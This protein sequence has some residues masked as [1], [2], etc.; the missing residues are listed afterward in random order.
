M[1]W[2]LLQLFSMFT[3]TDQI[4]WTGESHIHTG[5]HHTVLKL[6]VSKYVVF[7][8]PSII[9][10]TDVKDYECGEFLFHL[11]GAQLICVL[12]LVK[13]T[14]RESSGMTSL[15]FRCWFGI[16]AKLLG[17]CW[18]LSLYED[19]VSWACMKHFRLYEKGLLHVVRLLLVMWHTQR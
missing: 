4:D 2:I 13:G 14:T 3:Q 12:I 11:P 18:V 1:S 7:L 10:R 8:C 16:T 19:V 5:Q 6:A 9:W 15:C 17:I